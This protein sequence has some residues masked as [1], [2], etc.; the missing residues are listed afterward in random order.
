V[1]DVGAWEP[2]VADHDPFD[3]L[4]G[5]TDGLE[6][7]EQLLDLA[8]VWLAPGGHVVIEI[9]D[10]RGDEAAAMATRAGL[11]EVRVERDLTQR[12][13]VLVARRSGG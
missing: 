10:R 5:G 1:T 9:D 8:G 4:V 12:D 2:E 7:V 3:A 6:I 13:R 11:V